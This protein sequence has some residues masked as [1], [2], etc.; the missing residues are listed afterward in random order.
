MPRWRRSSWWEKPVVY[1]LGRRR[2]LTGKPNSHFYNNFSWHIHTSFT[3]HP[4]MIKGLWIMS[5]EANSRWVNKWCSHCG[6]VKQWDRNCQGFLERN[7]RYPDRLRK[8]TSLNT[9]HLCLHNEAF[10]LHQ[11]PRYFSLKTDRNLSHQLS[12]RMFSLVSNSPVIRSGK[13]SG[14][15]TELNH[16]IIQCRKSRRS[17]HTEFYASSSG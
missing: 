16:T 2:E 5:V 6:Q 15:W 11:L 3:E 13:P 17:L 14:R 9:H 12:Q 7:F 1:P 10:L 4:I 8:R